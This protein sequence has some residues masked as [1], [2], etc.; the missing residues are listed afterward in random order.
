MSQNSSSEDI[1]LSQVLIRFGE[2]KSYLVSKWKQFLLFA[3]AFATLGIALSFILKPKYK[4]NLT[5]VL[6]ESQSE[7]PLGAYAGIASQFGFDLGGMTGSNVFSEDN[8]TELLSSRKIVEEALLNKNSISGKE[9]LLVNHFMD[10]PLLNKWEDEELL[11]TIRFPASRDS[12]TTVQDSLLFEIFTLVTEKYLTVKNVSAKSTIL[13]VEC[14]SKDEQFSKHLVENLMKSVTDFYISN[15]TQRAR[16]TV[17]FVKGRTDS[18]AGALAS[19]ELR[20]AKYKDSRH[21]TVRAEGYMEELRL[22]RDVQILNAMY[23]EAVKNLELSKVTLLN[24]TPLIQVI[25]NPIL[26][27]EV[28]EITPLKGIVLGALIGL[29]LAFFWFLVKKIAEDAV[30]A[31]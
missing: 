6:E 30:A 12:F 4:A 2:I 23:G 24:Q 15:K 25:D 18:I 19:A 28:V 22:T 26:P 5:F 16:E 10:S 3:L 31:G 9:Q 20:L 27:L 11:G 7:S 21:L 1:T 29:V 13:L 14:L 17:A 8:L